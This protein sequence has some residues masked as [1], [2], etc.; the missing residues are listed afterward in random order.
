MVS[1][2]ATKTN[3]EISQIY[4]EAVPEK[5][6]EGKEIWQFGSFYGLSFICLT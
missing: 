2:F 3:R 1:Q 4:E 5:H 6:E